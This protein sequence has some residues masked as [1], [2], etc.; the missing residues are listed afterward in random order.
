MKMKRVKSL[1]V[2]KV[3]KNLT[4]TLENL[5]MR[6]TLYLSITTDS[7]SRKEKK[8]TTVMVTGPANIC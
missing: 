4:G 2:K 5:T 3:M 6:H 8:F 7:L 1:L